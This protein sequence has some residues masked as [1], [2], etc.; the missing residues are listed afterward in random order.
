MLTHKLKKKKLERT[1]LS[2]LAKVIGLRNAGSLQVGEF[3]V[4]TDFHGKNT[5]T[6]S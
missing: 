1:G 2:V 4:V 5:P 6:Y 3:N